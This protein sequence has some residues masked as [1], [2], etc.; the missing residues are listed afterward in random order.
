MTSATAA[1]GKHVEL[2]QYKWPKSV[3]ARFVAR[4]MI[5]SSAFVALL[6]GAYTAS[7]TIGYTV[8]YP[9]VAERA[10][11]IP[12]FVHNTG[13]VAIIGSPYSASS[14]LTVPGVSGW[15]TGGVMILFGAIWGLLAATRN[16]RGEEDLGRAEL[17]L[18]GETTMARRTANVLVGLA[19]SLVVLFAVL[20]ITLIAIGADHAVGYGATA[21]LFFAWTVTLAVAMFMSIGALTSQV[22]PTRTRASGLAIGIFGVFYLLR[23]I[24]DITNVTW[25]L[26]VTPLG[27]VEQMQP[28]GADRAIWAVPILALTMLCAGFA[29]FLA[30]RRDMGAAMFADHD[31]SPA[32]TGLLNSVLGVSVRLTRAT[33]LSWLAGIGILGFFMGSLAKT[34]AQAFDASQSFEHYLGGLAGGGVSAVGINSFLSIVFLLTNTALMAYAASAISSMREDEAQGYLDNLFVG[35][36]S[37]VRWIWQRLGL[38]TVYIVVIALFSGV[39]L[40]AGADIQHT[41]AAFSGIWRAAINGVPAAF[42]TLSVGVLFMGLL[43]RFT[44]LAAYFVIGWSFLIVMVSSGLNISHWVLDTSVLHHITLAPLVAPAWM[45]DWKIVGISIVLCAVGVLAFARR[46]LANE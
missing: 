34:A 35:P 44:S 6:F 25:L 11:V 30:G 17:L 14:M 45:T 16:L 9:T 40:W 12:S 41:G 29:I 15:N 19:G 3:I 8:T 20:A 24:G 5:R 13:L 33:S 1:A 7:K 27:W 43:P 37:R 4:R 23:A 22:M 2:A 31:S 36:I 46:D 26:K 10:A 39:A 32:H 21:G 18:A 42:F 28:L 38:V